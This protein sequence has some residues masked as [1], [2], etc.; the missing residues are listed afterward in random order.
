MVSR[1]TV[2]RASMVPPGDKLAR[3][4]CE[5]NVEYDLLA[6]EIIRPRETIPVFP[7][8]GILKKP[9]NSARRVHENLLIKKT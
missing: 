8:R 1:G 4:G 9:L 7:L 5:R 6:G 2:K 3:A